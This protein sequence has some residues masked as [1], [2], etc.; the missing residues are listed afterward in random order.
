VIDI[1]PITRDDLAAANTVMQA[2]FNSNN[3]WSPELLRY[4]SYQPNRWLIAEDRGSPAATVGATVYPDFAYIG[5]MCVHPDHQR[6]GIGKALM[7][8]V[9]DWLEQHS[10]SIVLLDA[11]ALGE[12]LYAKLGFVPEGR[13]PMLDYRQ[14]TPPAL[15]T[16]PVDIFTRDDLDAVIQFDAGIFGT[17]RPQVLA[18][19]L[20]DYPERSFLTRNADGQISGYLI[21]SERRLGPWAASDPSAADR[22]VRTALQLPFV[23]TPSVIMP[24]ANKAGID[25]LI[26]LGFISLRSCTH[27]RRG[28]SKHPAQ[29]EQLYG[30]ASYAIG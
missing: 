11:T 4:M 25:M 27:M 29:I 14:P 18:Q 2:A 17:P 28:G 26:E 20:N 30:Q 15:P 9:L 7:E 5:M 24:Y 3:D 8:N 22:L 10:C 13:R 19:M 23:I 12:P 21:A 1:R 6:K 16:Q